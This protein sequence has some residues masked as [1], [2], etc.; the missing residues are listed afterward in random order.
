MLLHKDTSK[1]EQYYLVYKIISTVNDWDITDGDLKVLSKLLYEYNELLLRFEQVQANALLFDR[2]IKLRIID[3]LKTTYNSFANS[4]TRLK[5][6]GFLS[7]DNTID[8]KF[9]LIKIAPT[10]NL[11]VQFRVV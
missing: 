5:K 8:P 3:E 2:T 7:K 9:L 11:T 10:M 4:L 1:Q 6:L